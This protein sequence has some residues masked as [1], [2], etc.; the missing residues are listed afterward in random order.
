MA[1]TDP[2]AITDIL[3]R[4]IAFDTVSAKSNLALVEAVEDLAR[5]AG[6]EIE[7]ITP[8][9]GKAALWITLGPGDVPGYVLSGHSDVV[10]T[11]GQPWTSDPFRLTE[12]D[13]RLYG[14]GTSDMKGFVAVCL[15]LMPEMAAARLARPIHI[16]LS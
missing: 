12:R 3:A 9:A 2:P 10:P 15:A 8:E 4:L 1:A 16:A 5:A 6:A 13:G 14:R 7:R 11:E